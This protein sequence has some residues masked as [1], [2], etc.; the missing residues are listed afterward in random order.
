M[1]P[2]RGSSR[3]FTDGPPGTGLG[4]DVTAL[5]VWLDAR[6]DQPWP[7]YGPSR[8]TM[9]GVVI[10]QEERQ[11]VRAGALY[12]RYVADVRAGEPALSNN[13]FAIQV[14]R[15]GWIDRTRD[16]RGYVYH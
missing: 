10:R 16:K 5:T 15:V 12:D 2:D 9:A 4:T 6:R 11:G 3:N 7:R 1:S 8:G 13:D 14:G